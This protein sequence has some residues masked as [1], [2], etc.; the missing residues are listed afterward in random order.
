MTKFEQYWKNDDMLK[1][2]PKK[3]AKK[4]YDK[5]FSLETI[6]VRKYKKL[7]NQPLRPTKLKI[8]CVDF[9]NEVQQ[10][11]TCFQKWGNKTDKGQRWGLPLVNETGVIDEPDDTIQPLDELYFETGKL[12]MD[13]EITEKTV[14]CMME[15]LEPLRKLYPYM[16]RS[17][18]LKWHWGAGFSRHRDIELPANH[19]RL[20]GTMS[21]KMILKIDDEEMRDIEPGRIYLIDVSKFHEG[22]SKQNHLYQLFLGVNLDAYDTLEKICFD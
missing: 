7:Y 4:F 1:N 15:S 14:A 8:N 17:A 21:D 13:V 10:Y 9:V 3:V 6:G 11:K 2:Y 16:I 5:F 19:L 12:L 20:W 22:I 18:V